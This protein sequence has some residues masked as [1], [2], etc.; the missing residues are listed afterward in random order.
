MSSALAAVEVVQVAQ[1]GRVQGGLVA[2]EG[3][4]RGGE[5][6]AE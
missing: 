3:G 1:V 4:V 6:Y 2:G 5:D